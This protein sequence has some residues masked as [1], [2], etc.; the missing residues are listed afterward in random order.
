MCSIGLDIHIREDF[1]PHMGALSVFY[2]T[3]FAV[4]KSSAEQPDM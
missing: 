2:K 4:G 3:F 1:T